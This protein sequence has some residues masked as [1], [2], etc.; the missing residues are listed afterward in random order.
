MFAYRPGIP[1]PPL[2]FTPCEKSAT[3]PTPANPS[4]RRRQRGQCPVR[5]KERPV[6]RFLDLGR[7]PGVTLLRF[8]LAIAVARAGSRRSVR[9]FYG[10]AA[11]PPVTRTRQVPRTLVGLRA[12]KKR[13]PFPPPT[14]APADLLPTASAPFDSRFQHTAQPSS[15]I[16]P[17]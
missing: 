15:R 2:P 14:T 8:L 6:L 1:G 5:G 13:P 7:D 3:T 10:S 9:R 4:S 17:F 11:P 12:R 16:F